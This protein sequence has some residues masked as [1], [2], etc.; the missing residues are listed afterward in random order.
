MPEKNCTNGTRTHEPSLRELTVDMDGKVDTINEKI[1]N[2]HNLIDERDR[3]YSERNTTQKVAVDAALT[4]AKEQ[5]GASF[6]SSEKAIVKAENAQSE[7]NAR[8]NEFRATLADQAE[9]LASKTELV[10][11]NKNL[12]DKISRHDDDIRILREAL[13]KTTGKDEIKT[14]G[15]AD[16]LIFIAIIIQ[17][18]MMLLGFAGFALALFGK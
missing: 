5:T 10:T 8:S 11:V 13:S 1:K 16:N 18:I 7:Y 3:L 6:A 9:R 17:T 2:L 14:T 15:K 4:A 12:E